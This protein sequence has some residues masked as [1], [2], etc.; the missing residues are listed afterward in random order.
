MNINII[1]MPLEPDVDAVTVPNADGTYTITVN[2]S[3]SE[4]RAK[5]AILH[6]VFHIK[7]DDFSDFQ[8]T[9]LI[10]RMLRESDYLNEEVSDINF[11]YHVV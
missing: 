7:N 2:S 11:F 3:L 8:H 1:I 5:K 4:E 6:E 9:S 10:E